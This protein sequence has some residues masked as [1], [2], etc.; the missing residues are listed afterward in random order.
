MGLGL[1]LGLNKPKGLIYFQNQFSMEFDGVDDRIITDDADTVAQSTTY[2]FWCKSSETGQNR[3]V[4]GHGNQDKGAFHFNYAQNRP[5]L[6]AGSSFFRYWADTTAQYDGEWHHWVVYYDANDMS[7]SKL[8]VD[9]VLQSV[10]STANT[11]STRE[12]YTESLT[13]GSQQQVSGN[14]FEGQIDEFAVFD[15][16]LTQAEITRMYNTY[17]TNNL[18]KNGNFEETGDEKVTNGDFSQIGGEEVTNGDFSQIGNELLSQPVDLTSNFVNNGGGVIVDADTFTTGGGALDGIVSNVILTEGKTYKLIISGNTTSSGFTIGNTQGSGGQYGTGFGTHYFTATSTNPI[19]ATKIWIRQE[20]AGTTNITSFSIKEVGQGWSF[21]TG[22]SMGDGVANVDVTS[23]AAL[24][25]S[26]TGLTVNGVYDITI[27]ISNYVEGGLQPQFGG[28]LASPTGANSDG[29]HNFKIVA[30]GSTQGL[31]LYALNTSKFTIDNISIKEVAQD[32][33]AKDGIITS[34]ENGKL[35]FDNSSGN[36]NGGVFQNIGLVTGKQ[37]KMTATMQLITGSSNGTF[38]LFTSSATGTGQTS[39]YT[40]SA[41]VAGGAAVTETFTFKPGSGDVS[42]QFTCDEANATY[43]ISDI[44]VKEVGQHWDFGTGWSTD[45]TKAIFTA[46]GAQ[47]AQLEQ[48]QGLNNGTTHKVLFDLVDTDSLGVYVRLNGGSWSSLITG[49]GSKELSIGAGGGNEIEFEIGPGYATKS[50]TIDNI[51]IQQLKHQATNLLVNSGDYQSASPLLTSTKSM[52]FDGIDDYLSVGVLPDVF[53]NAYTLSAWV[54][55]DTGSGAHQ[56]ISTGQGAFAQ[57]YQSGTGLRLKIFGGTGYNADISTDYFDAA[58]Q[59]TWVH[60]VLVYNGSTIKAYRN[61]IEVGSAA[62]SGTLDSITNEANIGRW[63]GGSEYWNGK[64]TEFGLYDR[65]LT[66]LEVASL[67][68]QGVPTD[69]LVNRNNYQSGNP[70]VFNTK[71]VDFDGVD[72]Y[73]KVTSD[74]GSQF[75]GSISFWVNRDDNTG[76]QYLF[77]PR[78]SSGGG[79][80]FAY[81]HIGTDN[82]I[83]SSGTIYVDGVAATVAPTDGNWHHVVITGITLNVNQYLTFGARY[84]IADFLDGKMSQVGLWNSTLTA[85]E[86]SS[87]YNHG[88]PIDL[89]KQMLL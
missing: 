26:L 11:V 64:I 89:T 6:Y 29:T 50:L 3:G 76:Y 25:Q 47:Y 62:L 39:V 28:T 13:I 87:L 45:G 61:G 2:S 1:G 60:F 8:Y 36:A 10:V 51:I 21:G 78:G 81:F 30:G 88:L 22:W 57:I 77:D 34:V 75:T 59:N 58:H 7:N 41:L 86:V 67:Y 69:L 63:L 37:Y 32:W 68:N 18:V 70:T 15:R 79:V 65:G 24:S 66:A 19:S 73:L 55:T 17:Y 35:L 12:A 56:I 14:S 84:N 20:T 27:T 23:T 33:S 72:D 9:G 44:S 52:E 83:V 53:R 54:W 42:I 43:S 38:N 16:E 46:G 31:L 5:L 74:Y 48:I 49:T 82:L 85:D 71:Q 80:G 40:G 4:F